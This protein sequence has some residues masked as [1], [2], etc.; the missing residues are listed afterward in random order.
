MFGQDF[1][2]SFE[3]GRIRLGELSRVPG[4]QQ[5]HHGGFGLVSQLAS[6]RPQ[7]LAGT[8]KLFAIL[9][10]QGRLVPELKRQTCLI[11]CSGDLGSLVVCSD[12]LVGLTFAVQVVRGA[13][14]DFDIGRSPDAADGVDQQEIG[15]RPQ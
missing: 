7:F 4:R 2:V 14:Q 3:R 11:C 10:H 15:R 1:G 12:R 8:C 9:F 13:R 6:Y 5:M